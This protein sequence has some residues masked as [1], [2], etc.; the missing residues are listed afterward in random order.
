MNTLEEETLTSAVRCFVVVTSNPA[1]HEPLPLFLDGRCTI[2]RKASDRPPLAPVYIRRLVY[3]SKSSRVENQCPCTRCRAIP[4]YAILR[5][6]KYGIAAKQ[7]WMRSLL[8]KRWARRDRLVETRGPVKSKGADS[9]NT[10]G[11]LF[12]AG[13]GYISVSIPATSA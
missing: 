10:S 6:S 7:R 11:Y 8:H 1:T 3:H 5:R 12:W 13:P 4:I 2:T 9:S